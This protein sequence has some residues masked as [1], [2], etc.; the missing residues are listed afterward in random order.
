MSCWHEQH[1]GHHRR[2]SPLASVLAW[3]NPIWRW[4]ASERYAFVEA[5]FRLGWPTYG[6]GVCRLIRSLLLPS[7]LCFFLFS[8][9]GFS[10]RFFT[11]FVR[12]SIVLF[13]FFIF[14]ILVPFSVMFPFLFSVSV[15]L[16]FIAYYIKIHRL[17]Q[18]LHRI[19]KIFI[20]YYEIVHLSFIK[21]FIVYYKNIHRILWNCSTP[22][23]EAVY[24]VWRHTSTWNHLHHREPVYLSHEPPLVSMP[25]VAELHGG[26]RG[27]LPPY[28]RKIVKYTLII[29][30]E[31]TRFLR[32]HA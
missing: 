7:S 20:I 31:Y 8:Y 10:S 13:Q 32:V 30:L 23:N 9:M 29:R 6:I 24:I 12:F 16:L 11:V 3:A 18:N 2:W 4:L 17:L 5:S 15:F 22:V 25:P 1:D 14:S 21:M 27:P 26:Q 19:K 28:S